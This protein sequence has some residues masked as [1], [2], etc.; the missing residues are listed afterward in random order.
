VDKYGRPLSDTHEQDNLRRFYRL[1]KYDEDDSLDA[2]TAGPDYARGTVLMESSDEE[3]GEKDDES[4][5]ED[6]VELG[7]AH[8]KPI[9]VLNDE[10]EIDL[11]E[12]NFDDLDAQAAMYSKKV[13]E[14]GEPQEAPRT[15]RLAVVNLD[16]DHVKAI[17]LYK[18]FSSAVS[19]TAPALA[20]SIKLEDSERLRGSNPVARGTVFSVR[21]YPSEFGKKRLAQ[22]EKEGPPPEIFKKR[23]QVD[24]TE[25]NERNIY[26]VGDEEEYD[27]V[28][29]RNY[30][31]E[32]LRSAS[33]YSTKRTVTLT[34]NRYYYAIVTCDTVDA[35]SHIYSE[36]NDTELERSAN[37][38]DL[39][40]VPDDMTFDEEFRYAMHVHVC[41]RVRD[42]PYCII[43][44]MKR[45][46][47]RALF[48]KGLISSHP[49]ASFML[50]LKTKLIRLLPAY[51][52]S[53]T[54]RWLLHGTRTTLSGTGS[55]D[56]L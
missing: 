18:I 28:A 39:S 14:E 51:R 1:E 42:S 17:H 24:K 9:T 53:V 15:R 6:I 16:W 45:L 7:H 55:H 34:G 54:R 26:E 8:S 27:D 12:T 36:L 31:L 50:F 30:Q 29:L 52:L 46:V 56:G 47:I 19:P 48:I 22:E 20:A 11:D 38:L 41:S 37:V 33:L 3:E 43:T 44:G 10:A 32:R 35:A 25:V 2:P 49:S 23:T 40:F 4:D 5:L 13:D 21:I